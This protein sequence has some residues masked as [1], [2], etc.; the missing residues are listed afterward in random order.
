MK[1]ERLR[2]LWSGVESALLWAYVVSVLWVLCYAVVPP[3]VT[4][5]DGVARAGGSAS[6]ALD[7]D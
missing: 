7:G 2:R 6:G 1:R 3:V 5:L 4:P